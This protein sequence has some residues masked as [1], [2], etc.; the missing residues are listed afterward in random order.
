MLIGASISQIHTR[1]LNTKLRRDALRLG[2]L[3]AAQRSFWIQYHY[4]KRG[5]DGPYSKIFV[6]RGIWAG[7]IMM[8]HWRESHGLAG[9]YARIQV[10]A[11]HIFF[12]TQVIRE[13]SVCSNIL[14]VRVSV[15]VVR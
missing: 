5:I 6:S 13:S 14:G 2:N 11:I 4:K 12:K 10:L 3:S 8:G 15:R 1:H 7:I 9:I